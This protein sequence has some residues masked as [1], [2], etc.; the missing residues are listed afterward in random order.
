M[1]R[2]TERGVA[3]SSYCHTSE[4]PA[5]THSP[6]SRKGWGQGKGWRPKQTGGLTA[7]SRFVNPNADA[8]R[9]RRGVAVEAGGPRRVERG[10]EAQ[11]CLGRRRGCR[12][13]AGDQ[14]VRRDHPRAEPEQQPRVGKHLQLHHRV[15]GGELPDGQRLARAGARR[16]RPGL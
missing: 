2:Q 12:G 10:D 4:Q 11:I 9:E 3:A 14:G 6:A 1:R 13:W 5:Q 15:T 7:I 8:G 16:E